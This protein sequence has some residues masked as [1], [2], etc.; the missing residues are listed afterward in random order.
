MSSFDLK[1][2]T[3]QGV[4]EPYYFVLKAGN[5]QIIAQSEMYATKQ[6]ALKGIESVKENAP[7][8]KINDL[9]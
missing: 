5:G 9:T 1:K 4:A 6:S 7:V 2:S 8:A 3:K